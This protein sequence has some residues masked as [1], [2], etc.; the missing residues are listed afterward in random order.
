MTLVPGFEGQDVKHA[1]SQLSSHG[2]FFARFLSAQANHAHRARV[3]KSFSASLFSLDIG[4]HFIRLLDAG[5]PVNGNE[6]NV[7]V[8]CC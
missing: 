5:S 8:R 2:P 1:H 4:V 3:R 7:P 6:N